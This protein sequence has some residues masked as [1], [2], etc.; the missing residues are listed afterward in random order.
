MTLIERLREAGYSGRQDADLAHE[1]ADE[2]ETLVRELKD[3]VWSL[4]VE[5][6]PDNSEVADIRAVI[7]RVTG[8]PC[9]PHSALADNTPC[10][11]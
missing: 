7:E 10:G 5:W 6:G 2:I 4:S 9:P 11:A 3:A 1:A 8:Q